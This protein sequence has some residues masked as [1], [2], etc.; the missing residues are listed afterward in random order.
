MPGTDPMKTA[1]AALAARGKD[2][3]SEAL[4][5][6]FSVGKFMT[7]EEQ[8]LLA[9]MRKTLPRGLKLRFLGGFE[10][11]ERRLP[12]FYDPSFGYEEDMLSS[13]SEILPMEIVSSSG[14]ELSHRQ[15]LGSLMS[16][17]VQRE[18]VG[19]ILPCTGGKAVFFTLA[20]LADFF[21]KQLCRVGRESVTCGKTVLAWDFKPQ[22]KTKE[23]RAT[24]ASLRLDCAAAALLQVSRDK[25]QTMIRAGLVSK[26]HLPADDP[27]APFRTGDRITIK[28]A[29][30]FDILHA[31]EED[32][33]RKGRVRLVAQQYID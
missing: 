10:E 29:G 14:A 28:G 11:A 32:R 31:E 6:G 8:A 22:R 3:A 30:R 17:G 12:L 24:I 5:D 20:P 13:L 18:V 15:I 1:A 23:I 9:Q 25:A 26:N 4:R 21:E 27:A 19:D 2:L 16:L 33:T 7:P